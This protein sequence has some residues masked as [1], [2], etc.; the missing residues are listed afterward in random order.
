MKRPK[1]NT[2]KNKCVDCG[3]STGSRH[4][5]NCRW[6]W[7]LPLDSKRLKKRL[8]W[9]HKLIIIWTILKDS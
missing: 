4:D 1:L 5:I 7:V 3:V 6:A 8:G 9:R 2:R